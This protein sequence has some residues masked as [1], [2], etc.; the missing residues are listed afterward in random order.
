M[1]KTQIRGNPLGIYGNMLFGLD[2]IIVYKL[3]A[4]GIR[5]VNY[6]KDKSKKYVIYVP[7]RV[8]IL[9]SQECV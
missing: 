6:N 4:K 3:N 5:L 8:Q 9:L 2:N 1:K 7:G